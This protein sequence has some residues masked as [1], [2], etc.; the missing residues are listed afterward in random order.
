[1]ALSNSNE[2]G[3]NKPII[4]DSE[5]NTSNYV[6]A[7]RKLFRGDFRGLGVDEVIDNVA[8]S[9]TNTLAINWFRKTA[10]FIAEFLLADAPE[11]TFGNDRFQ[12][13]W[14]ELFPSMLITLQYT[15]LDMLRYGEGVFASHPNN[16]I[17]I[18]RFERDQHF[19]VVNVRGEVTEDIFYRIRN[20]DKFADVYRYPVNG[21]AVWQI[22][23]Y[24]ANNL[25][26]LRETIELP[27]RQGRQVALLSFNPEKTSIFDDMAGGIGEMTRIATSVAQTIEKNLRPHLYGPQG[28]IIEDESGKAELNVKGMFFPIAPGEV[29]PG[30][31]QWDSKVDAVK[32]AYAQHERNTLALGSIST[33]LFDPSLLT[34]I[35][36][37]TALRR[38]L[39][40]FTAKL[41]HLTNVNEDA[42]FALANIIINN[43][44]A[45]GEELISLRRSQLSVDWKYEQLFEEENVPERTGNSGGGNSGGSE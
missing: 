32:W 17:S 1:M 42:I 38:L 11:I 3:Q 39:I 19:E 28:A 12:E 21:D 41:S 26:A 13:L 34:G 2:V 7:R 25:G 8:S 22:Y 37:G 23:N 15:N 10:T 27:R 18:V 45:Q 14:N 16:P 44:G 4:P 30:Y 35:L 9:I 43:M 31:L 29:T 40:P 5:L 24:E 6:K 20:N 36:S 33:A